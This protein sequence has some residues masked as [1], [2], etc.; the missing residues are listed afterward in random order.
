MFLTVVSLC[1]GFRKLQTQQRQEDTEELE[2]EPPQQQVEDDIYWSIINK[3]GSHEDCPPQST[4]LKI[5][6]PSRTLMKIVHPN[7]SRHPTPKFRLG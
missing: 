7:R 3:I 5:V 2:E 4:Q 1:N 6:H